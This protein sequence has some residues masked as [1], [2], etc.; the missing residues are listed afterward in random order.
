MPRIAGKW[1]VNDHWSHEWQQR[2]EFK[3][4]ATDFTK[5][6]EINPELPYDSDEEDYPLAFFP[7]TEEQLKK[8]ADYLVHGEKSIQ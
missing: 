5:N 6:N 8:A 1:S 2:A 4:N 7:E 3:Q